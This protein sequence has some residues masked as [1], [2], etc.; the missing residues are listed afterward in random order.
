MATYGQ[1]FLWGLLLTFLAA[2]GVASAL[3][4]LA[5]A[6]AALAGEGLARTFLLVAAVPLAGGS[7]GCAAKAVQ[8]VWHRNDREFQLLRAAQIV[9]RRQENLRDRGGAL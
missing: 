2:C 6:Q 8:D 5:L 7:A 1:A 9:E 4:L 3:A